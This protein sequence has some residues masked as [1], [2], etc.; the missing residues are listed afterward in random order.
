MLKVVPANKIPAKAD[1]I[2]TPTENLVHLYKT[3]QQMYEVCWQLNG[4][5]LSAVQVGIPW[6]LCVVMLKSGKFRNIVNAYYAPTEDSEDI[7]SLEGCLSLKT[8]KGALRHFEVKR[9]SKIVVVGKELKEENG[10]LVLVDFEETMSVDDGR[11]AI[12]F[13]HE[14]DHHLSILISDIG[15]EIQLT[16]I[17]AK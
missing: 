7:T 9:C 3:C 10:Q 13:Q 6:R 17:N 1:I 4:I 14:I 2:D 5:G 15:K 8:K 12:V 11:D 16:R